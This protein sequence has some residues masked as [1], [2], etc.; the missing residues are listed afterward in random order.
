MSSDTDKKDSHIQ[1]KQNAFFNF[2]RKQP[3]ANNKQDDDDGGSG[4]TKNQLSNQ[5]VENAQQ[6]SKFKKEQQDNK[7]RDEHKEQL[8]QEAT[9]EK[10][11]QL[12]T[13]LRK[14]YLQRMLAP[15]FAF[16]SENF[17]VSETRS[18][19]EQALAAQV[20][21]SDSTA[22]SHGV[23]PTVF[24]QQNYVQI[25]GAVTTTIVGPSGKNVMAMEDGSPIQNWH[26]T[27]YFSPHATSW[28]VSMNYNPHAPARWYVPTGTV[29]QAVNSLQ[30]NHQSS[31]R[32]LFQPK[33]SA[34]KIVA[35]NPYS[36]FSHKAEKPQSKNEMIDYI[37]KTWRK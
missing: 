9:K 31:L 3:M 8:E 17:Q 12:D 23:A 5:P 24:E 37:Q 25:L 2:A 26:T 30:N 4:G 6:R 14:K 32:G 36:G 34:Q 11:N 7:D 13:Q 20:R 27:Q 28:F 1:F 22:V 33:R 10:E 35:Q 16:D 15:E 18:E 21:A 19:L 29:H